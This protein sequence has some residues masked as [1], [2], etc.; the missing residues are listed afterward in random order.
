[1]ASGA[2]DWGL[3]LG[4]IA[5]KYPSKG[6]QVPCRK[7]YTIYVDDTGR[8]ANISLSPR[9]SNKRYIILSVGASAETMIPCRLTFSKN[10]STIGTHPFV[11]HIQRDFPAGIPIKG[12]DTFVIR[13][14]GP[15]FRDNAYTSAN[16]TVSV[17]VEFLEVTI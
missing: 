14:D 13:G 17:W 2:P 5:A 10:G 8:Y 1:M 16:M 11:G 6:Y 7:Y 4:K 3:A 9:D 15:R 12:S